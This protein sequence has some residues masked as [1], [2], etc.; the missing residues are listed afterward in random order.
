MRKNVAPIHGSCLYRIYLFSETIFLDQQG[1]EPGASGLLRRKLQEEILRIFFN[2]IAFSLKFT[3]V[4]MHYTI[5][6]ICAR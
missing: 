6:L 4:P 3:R 1:F 5:I 2:Q